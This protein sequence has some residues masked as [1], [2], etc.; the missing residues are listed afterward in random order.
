MLIP[1]LL[2][3][4]RNGDYLDD[5]D[6][7]S[8]AAEAG[9]PRYRVEEVISFFPH[10]RRTPPPRVLVQVCRDMTCHFRGA[11]QIKAEIERAIRENPL[12]DVRVEGVS[13]LGRCDRGPAMCVSHFLRQKGV[14]AKALFAGEQRD[15]DE[16]HDAHH[17][18][19]SVY[20][21]GEHSEITAVQR[22]FREIVETTYRLAEQDAAEF[23]VAAG[24]PT[25]KCPPRATEYPAPDLDAAPEGAED[26]RQWKINVYGRPRRPSGEWM[27][28]DAVRL[29]VERCRE[30]NRRA[31]PLVQ[32]GEE[33]KSAAQALKRLEGKRPTDADA[34]E[35]TSEAFKSLGTAESTLKRAANEWKGK[36]DDAAVRANAAL[37]EMVTS[38]L[39]V[40]KSLLVIDN[41]EITPE[42]RTSKLKGGAEILNRNAERLLNPRGE[43]PLESAA[44]APFFVPQDVVE[45]WFKVLKNSRLLGMGGG[46]APAEGKWR[47]VRDSVRR[48]KEIGNFSAAYVVANGDESEPGTFKDREL[49]LRCPELVVEGVII[50]GLLTGATKGYIFIR[51]EYQEQIERIT[52]AIR[53]ARA[54]RIC[55]PDVL[56][57][58][59]PFPV[60][61]YVSP[62]GYICGE[63]SALLEAIE[64]R[65][66]QPRDRPPELSANGLFGQ[67]TLVSNVE[68]F[69]WS[70]AI[71]LEE[72]ADPTW[73]RA[74]SRDNMGWRLFSIS[75]DLERSGVYEMEV[76]E[77]LGDLVQR[78]GGV[79]GGLDNLGA[80]ATSGPS[81]GFVPRFLKIRREG[82]EARWDAVRRAAGRTPRNERDEKEIRIANSI[83]RLLTDDV[84]RSLTLDVLSMPLDLDLF[85]SIDEL[86]GIR[87]GMLLG[88]GLVVYS[89]DRNMLDQA[90]NATAFFR[91]ETCG[92]C[93]PCRLGSKV[94]AELG[95]DL[96]EGKNDLRILTDARDCGVY[97]LDE[98]MEHTS[99]CSLGKSAGKPLS[100]WFEH[101]D[102]SD[103]A[104]GAQRE[105]G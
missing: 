88:A 45:A 89:R 42:E 71:F 9:V 92:K 19:E 91:N 14:K 16:A 26:F 84:R 98:A 49:M 47:S 81:A 97:A 31:T 73:Y 74:K 79:I 38:T 86:L 100:S 54:A 68:T 101:F 12:A 2:E 82:F 59:I 32:G 5:D 104:A 43:F 1:R 63:Q 62:G 25:V 64:D 52:A 77:T 50:A 93:V 21:A 46:G 103:D 22:R 60:E 99:I 41:A 10:F 3:L 11:P 67:P 28:F 102:E 35:L 48:M 95:R 36:S 96:V 61:V 94:L 24:D 17:H 105:R 69:G 57:T 44:N 6:L 15:K 30:A 40:M 53:T 66:A 18:S 87:T 8:A 72:Q 29:F 70:P 83:V 58:G 37:H 76:A 51:H 13:C 56:G 7:T 33:L 39:E 55:G 85:R 27:G 20:L 23:R 4:Q 75:G 78:A 80:I 65:R 90:A 34:F